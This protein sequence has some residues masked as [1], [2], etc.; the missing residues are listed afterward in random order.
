MHENKVA[1]FTK[2]NPGGGQTPPPFPVLSL[3]DK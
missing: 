3:V 1:K 2:S